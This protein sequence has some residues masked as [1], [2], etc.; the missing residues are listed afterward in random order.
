MLGVIFFSCVFDLVHPDNW[1]QF[2]RL[3]TPSHIEP[4]IYFLWTFAII[5][6]HSGKLIGFTQL[7]FSSSFPVGLLL[8]TVFALQTETNFPLYY[9]QPELQSI[10]STGS[11]LRQ[12]FLVENNTAAAHYRN[13]ILQKTTYLRKRV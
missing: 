1:N 5:K 8:A 4:E 6:L 10:V 3:A 11:L 7:N 9:S 12:Y 2:S 13:L